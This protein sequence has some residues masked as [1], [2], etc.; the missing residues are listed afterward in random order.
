MTV[1][2]LNEGATET[3]VDEEN[4]NLEAEAS[5]HV[6]TILDTDMGFTFVYL[7]LFVF[8]IRFYPPNPLVE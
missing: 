5:E 1:G 7:K 4:T 8:I 3:V 2:G 6:E